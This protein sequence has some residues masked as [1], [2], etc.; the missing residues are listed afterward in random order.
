MKKIIRISV[1]ALLFSNIAMAEGEAQSVGAS[2]GTIGAELEYSRII[3]PEYNLAVR[4]SVGG[5]HW[6]GDYDDTDAHYDTDVDLFN[7]GAISR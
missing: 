5:V 1:V 7:M 6:S 3:Q 2:V 4:V